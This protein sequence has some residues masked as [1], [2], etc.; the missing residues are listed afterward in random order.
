MLCELLDQAD[1]SDQTPGETVQ[2]VDD[3][4][5]HLVVANADEQAMQRRAVQRC[6]G[7]SVVVKA[8]IDKGSSERMLG[9]DKRAAKVV[10]DFA[11]REA[12]V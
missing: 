3:D 2:A 11:R 5:I 9:F 10:L 7:N 1:A 6:S 12:V 8:L 4:L